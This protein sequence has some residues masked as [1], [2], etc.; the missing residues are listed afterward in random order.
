[1]GAVAAAAFRIS[2]RFLIDLSDAV[3]SFKQLPT[4]SRCSSTF[5]SLVIA[6]I[7]RS[8]CRQILLARLR[9]VSLS[10]SLRKALSALPAVRFRLNV[11]VRLPDGVRTRRSVSEIASSKRCAQSFTGQQLS[12]SPDRRPASFLAPA[13]R[14]WWQVTDDAVSPEQSNR[15]TLSCTYSIALGAVFASVGPPSL[16]PR[17]QSPPFSCTVSIRVVALKALGKVPGRCRVHFAACSSDRDFVSATSRQRRIGVRISCRV[18]AK[19]PAS[20]P[21]FQWNRTS[22]AQCRLSCWPGSFR[23]KGVCRPGQRCI[24][25]RRL[26]F[27]CGDGLSIPFR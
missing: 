12:A 5:S 18:K 26:F 7:N 22:I 2:R 10:A 6:S 20:N 23:S 13:A 24:E 4:L 14:P 16:D 21:K 27:K 11:R 25:E 19:F 17:H 8:F 15:H 3:F 9:R 1:V